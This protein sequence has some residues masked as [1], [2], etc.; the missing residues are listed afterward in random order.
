MRHSFDFP[1]EI[2][3]KPYA[4]HK[5]NGTLSKTYFTPRD[6]VPP[7]LEGEKEW[8]W[9]DCVELM[10]QKQDEARSIQ[11]ENFTIDFLYHTSERESFYNLRLIVRD[12]LPI[13]VRLTFND[14]NE[15]FAYKMRWL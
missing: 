5:L 6:F 8:Y 11:I 4:M 12:C 14:P 7:Y 3:A 2:T 9:D 13:G 15:A 1:A 10:I